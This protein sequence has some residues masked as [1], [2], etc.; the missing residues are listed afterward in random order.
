MPA[1]AV[2][3]LAVMLVVVMTACGP[4]QDQVYN[5]GETE[6]YDIPIA[7]QD[8]GSYTIDYAT[9]VWPIFYINCTVCHNPDQAQYNGDLDLT[10]YEAVMDSSNSPNAPIVIPYDP[11]DSYLV[12]RIEGT[13]TPIMPPT[14]PY[15]TQTEISTIWQWIEEGA[16][17][18]LPSALPTDY[19]F[20]LYWQDSTKAVL[21]F[22]WDL[23]EYAFAKVT[24]MDENGGTVQEIYADWNFAG[25]Y[26]MQLDVAALEAGVYGAEMKSG[27]FD[28]VYWFQIGM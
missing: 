21:L 2:T 7:P 22:A 5:P 26:V 24:F 11:D 28:E 14:A 19:D 12:K 15:L 25:S 27:V 6:L 1:V 3:V 9:D 8:T 17:E 4:G 13:V 18:T 20:E 23:P 10:S 16:L